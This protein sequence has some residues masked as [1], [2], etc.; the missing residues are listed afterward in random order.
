MAVSSQQVAIFEQEPWRDL[1]GKIVMVT[2]ASSGLGWEFCIDL[3][4]CGCRII[5]AARRT[6]RLK[7]LCHEINN[8]GQVNVREAGNHHVL[9]VP[10]EL[11]VTAGGPAIEASVK[12]AWEA[13]GRIDALINNAG[14]TGVAQNSL[15]LSEEDWDKTFRTN[16]KGAWLVSKYVG[17]RMRPLNQAGSI[18][19]ISSVTGHQRTYSPGSLAYASSK[20]ALNTMTK[21]MAMELGKN[22]IRVNSI[23]PGLYKSEITEELM[24]KK[25]LKELISKLVP[26][27]DF[28][29]IDP[30][31]TSLV[32]YLICD[33]SDYVTGNIFIVDAGHTLTGVPIYSSL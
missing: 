32:R 23:C 5:A 3:A 16:L 12:K 4:K 25:G 17:L 31:L 1:K 15:D 27:G 13:F 28:G 11:D 18:I 21:V 10:V 33:T 19:N 8:H 30:A 9:A 6:D 14:I 2:G 7:A 20:S 29:T 22:K 24:R 26:L